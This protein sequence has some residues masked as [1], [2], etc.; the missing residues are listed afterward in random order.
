MYEEKN[1]R[2]VFFRDAAE[3]HHHISDRNIKVS[4]FLCSC[5]P[6]S[7]P[8]E[9]SVTTDLPLLFHMDVPTVGWQAR[10]GRWQS[11]TAAIGW[12]WHWQRAQCN[13][14]S[15]YVLLPNLIMAGPARH[16]QTLTEMLQKEHTPSRA[17]H[18]QLERQAAAEAKIFSRFATLWTLCART[19]IELHQ[20]EFWQHF[21]RQE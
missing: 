14:V 20:R 18:C 15:L 19:P 1:D 11:L 16:C 9:P 6:H 5:S 3:M 12:Q 10:R 4:H 17:S 2:Y 8:Q 21:F 13:S 7:S